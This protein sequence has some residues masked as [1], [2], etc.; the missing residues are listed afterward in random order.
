MDDNYL[1]EHLEKVLN[2]MVNENI[3]VRQNSKNQFVFVLNGEVNR[4]SRPIAIYICSGKMF[5]K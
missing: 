1:K 5:T 2:L 3:S 4:I